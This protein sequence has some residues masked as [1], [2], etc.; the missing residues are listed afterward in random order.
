[1]PITALLFDVH[2]TLVDDSGFPKEYIWPLIQATNGQIELDAYYHR[3]S[4]LGHKLFDWPAIKPFISIRQIHR[5][6]LALLYQEY[7]VQRDLDRDLNYLWS[8]MGTCQIYPDVF[9]VIPQL[10][11]RF[12]IGLLTNADNDDPLIQILFSNGF[13]F[14][15]VMTS[16]M[17]K[18]YKPDTFIFS[19]MLKAMNL[20]TNEVLVIGD[21]PVSD[22]RGARNANLKVVWLNRPCISLPGNSP[23]PD[24][25]IHHLSELLPILD[26]LNSD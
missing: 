14:D 9:E 23:I 19:E 12:K 20:N 13:S 25:E 3:Y 6:R 18:C 11:K 4:Q 15:A 17:V 5:Q 24:F 22:I 1:M 2:R 26:I 7:G 21:S 16:E 8:R 10:K